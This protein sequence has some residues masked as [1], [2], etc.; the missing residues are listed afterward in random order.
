MD[1]IVN[2]GS[3]REIVIVHKTCV[4]DFPP[5]FAFLK[6]LEKRKYKITLIVGFEHP[7]LEEDLKKICVNYHNL[8]IIPRK[9]KILYWYNVRRAFWK[10]I[11]NNN[12]QKQLLWIP[13]ADTTIALGSRLLKYNFVLNLYEL[14]DYQFM[15]LRLLRKFSYKA[16]LVICSDINRS[17]ILRVWWKLKETPEVILNKPYSMIAGKKLSL[18][19]DLETLI[20]ANKSHKILIYQGL[21]AEE[22]G[23]FNLCKVINKLSDYKLIIMGKQNKYSEF[24]IQTFPNII[25]ISFV[26]PPYHLHITSHAHIGILSYDHSSLNNIFCAPNKLWEFSNFGL[27]M[28]GNNIPGL[29]STIEA[30]NMGKCVDFKNEDDVKNAIADIDTNYEIYSNSALKFYENYNYDKELDRIMGKVYKKN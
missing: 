8:N 18:S 15:Y 25:H 23:L 20:N 26:A 19:E 5:L 12:Y 22:R 28:L 24:L 3:S 1:K 2:L 11:L 13:A 27:P 7:D 9:N 10:C 30:N 21:I 17:N 4:A 14:F 29:I 16:Q 6:Y